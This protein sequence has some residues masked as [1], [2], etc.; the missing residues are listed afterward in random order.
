MSI[1]TL[2]GYIGSAKQMVIQKKTAS[3]TSVGQ[4]ITSVFNQNGLPG[5]GTLAGTNATT[6]VVPDDTTT[7]CPIINAFTGTKGYITRVNGFGSVAGSILLVDILLKMGTFAYN[8]AVT[9]LTSADIS[10]RVPAN[11]WSGLEIWLE[12][13]TAMTGNQTIAITYID[14]ADQARTTGSIA[15]GVA[16]I[17]GRCFRMPLAAAGVG[18]KTIT[19]VTS[20]ISSAGTFNVLI[21]R[22]LI[23]MRIPLAGYSESRDLYGTGM[24]EIYANS[25]LAVY[26][27]PDSTASGTPE[28]EIEI[29]NA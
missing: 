22:P 3:I 15:T 2:D 12:Q 26:S 20:T 1:S 4:M 24:P 8:A 9:G 5:A 10:S 28:F 23:N 14:G 21:V 6:G 27:R 25:A 16:P 29:A 13:V 18:V 17:V 7:G 19:G 11:G